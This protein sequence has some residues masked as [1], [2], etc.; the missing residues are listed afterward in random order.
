MTTLTATLPTGKFVK[1]GLW[2][3]QIF[4]ATAFIAAGSAKLAGVS[5][6]VDIFQQI[7]VGQWFR[8]LTGGIEVVAGLALLFPVLAAFGALT[9]S[10]TMIGAVTTHLFVIGGNP[11]PAFVL[12]AITTTIA[13]FRRGAILS[14]LL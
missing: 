13:W 9:L 5:M 2:T 1:A 11:T 7:G 10:A 6:M 12:L 14:R 3:L 4:A 8:Y